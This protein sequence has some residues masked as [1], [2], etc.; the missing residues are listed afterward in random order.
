MGLF[1]VLLLHPYSP[2]DSSL[3]QVHM[4]ILLGWV[5]FVLSCPHTSFCELVDFL[6]Y[7]HRRL[8]GVFLTV[9]FCY[10]LTWVVIYGSLGIVSRVVHLFDFLWWVL[11]NLFWVCNKVVNMEVGTV[12]AGLSDG[13]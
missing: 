10:M 9:G 2:C 12:L 1:L 3:S 6:V 13:M 7:M 5:F 11:V 8:G 4:H